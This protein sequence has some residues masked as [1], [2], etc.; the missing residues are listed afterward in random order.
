MCMVEVQVKKRGK[1]GKGENE[2]ERKESVQL[3]INPGT[4][5]K[6]SKVSSI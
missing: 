1:W 5:L 2:E 6:K 4:I 3:D